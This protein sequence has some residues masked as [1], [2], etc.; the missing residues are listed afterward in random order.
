MH[1]TETDEISSPKTPNTL[2]GRGRRLLD[3]VRLTWI[4]FMHFTYICKYRTVDRTWCASDPHPLLSPSVNWCAFILLLE[5]WSKFCALLY[6][7]YKVGVSSDPGKAAQCFLEAAKQGNAEAQRRLADLYIQG[8]GVKRSFKDASHWY[9]EAAEQGDFKA[10]FELACLL[11]YGQGVDKD[12][13]GALKWYQEA[14]L[15]D[16]TEA[17][18]NLAF[19]LEHGSKDT[20]QDLEH[21][22]E[23]YRRAADHGHHGA[24]RRLFKLVRHPLQPPQAFRDGRSHTMWSSIAKVS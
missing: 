19:L 21:A 8:R 4:D 5:C 20:Q 24:Q 1:N 3:G 2:I 13:P 15:H 23:W 22:L 14:A 6:P 10:Q 11:E 12:L 18:Y 7:S 16:C 9:L 17:Q